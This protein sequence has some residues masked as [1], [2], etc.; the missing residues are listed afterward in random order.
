VLLA[1]S[2]FNIVSENKFLLSAG[3]TTW[4]FVGCRQGGKAKEPKHET[5]AAKRHAPPAVYTA[6]EKKRSSWLKLAVKMIG[7][8][9]TL[10]AALAAGAQRS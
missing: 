5:Q 1:C 10:A 3:Y 4:A 6:G 9:W 7:K 8:T 2:P